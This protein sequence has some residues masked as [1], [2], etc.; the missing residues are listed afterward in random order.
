MRKV[1]L[2]STDESI[3]VLGQ[4]TYGIFPGR[5]EF[6]Y[7]KWKQALRK[8]IELGMTHI[9]TAE[10]YGGGYS[11]KIVGDVLSSLEHEDI[12]IESKV[13][14]SRE[15]KEDIKKAAEESLNRLRVNNVDLYL[16]HWL[17]E[18]SSIPTIMEALEEL[19]DDGITRFIGVSNFS[20]DEFQEA[21]SCLN[22]NELV[23][24]Q[25]E[26]NLVKQDEIT[27]NL[28]FYQEENVTLIAYSPLNKNNF[29]GLT[30]RI[31]KNLKKIAEKHSA[32]IQQ[33]ALAWLIN[34]DNVVAIPRSSSIEHIKENAKSAEIELTDD[35]M[36]QLTK[37]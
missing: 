33:I 10:M 6:F 25:V 27:N 37:N 11:E 21:Q 7:M 32:T 4:G 34:H 15:T 13:L 26:I 5:N 1:K 28:D 9:D 18:E 2:G 29:S 14:P 12:F 23:T 30:K 35:E 22:K 24:N 17:E 36:D 3:S 20:L 8:G 19:V 31:R 16:I